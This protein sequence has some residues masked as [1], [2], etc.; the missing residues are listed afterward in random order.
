MIANWTVD[1][2]S[3]T[4]VVSSGHSPDTAGQL[5]GGYSSL[6]LQSVEVPAPPAEPGDVLPPSLP[7]SGWSIRAS[8]SVQR[9]GD[10]YSVPFFIRMTVTP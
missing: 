3:E 10:T 5:V 4:Q 2:A 7:P 9:A 8:V 6:A 1:Y